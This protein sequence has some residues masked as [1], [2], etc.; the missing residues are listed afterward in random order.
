MELQGKGESQIH[1]L[2]DQFSVTAVL[3]PMRGKFSYHS[4]GN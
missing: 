3:D 1:A 4:L 2:I